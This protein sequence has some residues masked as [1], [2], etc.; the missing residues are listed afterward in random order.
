MVKFQGNP[1]FKRNRFPPSRR[2]RRRHGFSLVE[3]L[4]VVVL[5]L[6]LSGLLMPALSRGRRAVKRTQCMSNMNQIGAGIFLF[7]ADHEGSFPAHERGPII[8]YRHFWGKAGTARNAEEGRRR[9]NPYIGFN[10][11]ATTTSSGPLEIFHCPA[12]SGRHLGQ[13]NFTYLPTLWDAVGYSYWLNM[14]GNSNVGEK[15]LYGRWM[16]EVVKPQTMVMAACEPFLA[17]WENKNPA[18]VSTFHSDEL[19]WAPVLFVDGHVAYTQAT[20]DA[21]TYEKGKDYTWVYNDPP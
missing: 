2:L 19:G 5:I 14:A 13:Y 9:F 7:L 20:F 8:G 11:I 18:W 16:S 1:F 10:G 17:Y 4:V 21:P 3:L 6:I 15:G 12:D